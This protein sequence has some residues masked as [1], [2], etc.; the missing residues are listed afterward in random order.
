MVSTTLAFLGAVR[1]IR[2][3]SCRGAIRS[4]PEG[5]R[6]IEGWSEVEVQ[7][8]VHLASG[9]VVGC[10]NLSEDVTLEVIALSAYFFCNV[11]FKALKDVV[12]FLI[13]P[14]AATVSSRDSGRAPQVPV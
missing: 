14:A 12:E 6:S 9:V 3:L 7:G 4:N 1:R 2:P 13:D 8:I 11:L 10:F 5:G